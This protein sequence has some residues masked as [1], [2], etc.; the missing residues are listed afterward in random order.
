MF[1]EFVCKVAAEWRR[2]VF[3]TELRLAFLKP[4]YQVGDI[5]RRY[6]MLIWNKGSSESLSNMKAEL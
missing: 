1:F 6:E 4:E 2:N 5:F 3:D